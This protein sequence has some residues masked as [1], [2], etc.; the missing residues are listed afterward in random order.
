MSC[1]VHLDE[2][3]LQ[4]AEKCDIDLSKVQDMATCQVRKQIRVVREELW[5]VQKNACRKTT[6]WL[7]TNLQDIARAAGETDW[8]KK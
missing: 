3:Q 8:E 4:Q 7:E 2:L 5:D 6:E 1:S